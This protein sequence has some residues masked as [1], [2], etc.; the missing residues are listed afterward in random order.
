M[1]KEPNEPARVSA[2]V[3]HTEAGKT[4]LM[5]VEG[6]GAGRTSHAA[7]CRFEFLSKRDPSIPGESQ[8][9]S[10]LRVQWAVR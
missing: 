4:I 2:K 10:P 3:E 9:G 6:A 7:T 1:S 5:P 8:D